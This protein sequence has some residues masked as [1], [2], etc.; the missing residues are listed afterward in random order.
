MGC[1]FSLTSLS[2]LSPLQEHLALMGIPA[3]PHLAKSS[4]FPPFNFAAQNPT[5]LKKMAGNVSWLQSSHSVIVWL[6]INILLGWSCG[7]C[8]ALVFLDILSVLLHQGMHSCRDWKYM[9]SGVINAQHCW[10]AAKENH[11]R[12]SG[13]SIDFAQ[14]CHGTSPQYLCCVIV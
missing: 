7:C 13:Y 9:G 6:D 2:R 14:P 1:F 10:I 12:T 4:T 11:F 8:C 3:Y 5:S